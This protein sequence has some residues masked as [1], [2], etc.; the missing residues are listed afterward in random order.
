L[1]LLAG[2]VAWGQPGP[3][4][5]SVA[6]VVAREVHA[7]RSFAG[8]VMPLRASVV[9][10]AVDGRVEEFLVNEGDRVTKGQPLARLRT[11]LLEIQIAGAKAE[12][13]LRKHEL[14][15]LKNGS[16]PEEIAQAQ[17]KAA[18]SKALYEYHR[19][20][21]QRAQA[22]R[23]QPR[24]ISEDEM[25]E[26]TSA[27][28]SALQTLLE[29]KA[30]LA[31]ALAGPRQER[32]QQAEARV[33][34]AEEAIHEL[35]DQL[36]KHTIVAPFDGYVVEENTEVGQWVIRGQAVAKV[37]E[38][39]QVDVQSL[40]LEDYQ[41]LLALGMEAVVRLDALP[42][43]QFTGRI[44]LVVPQADLRSRSFPVKVRLDNQDTPGGPLLK[45]GMLAR[46]SLAV[47][48][49]A[50]ALLAPK[51][52]L[53]LGSEKPYVVA[54]EGGASAGKPGKAR[55]VPVDVGAAVEGLIQIRPLADLKPG[56]FVIVEGNERVR[57]GQDVVI[58][59]IVEA[60]AARTAAAPADEGAAID[61]NPQRKQG[62]AR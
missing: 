1:I 44:A 5:V 13:E 30:A 29:S 25:Q 23:N 41:P 4:P 21:L 55:P 34:F 45:P 46:V 37:V 10:S 57:P 52:A 9:G 58:A 62:E 32:I 60:P 8:T 3:V 59:K 38:L 42:N 20:R 16:R 54:A 33:A 51:D 14:A 6:A 40:V 11:R 2:R 47:G 18:A 12:H 61:T 19:G 48:D 53:V 15:E 27:T 22:L 28:E 31:L 56:D 24:A 35:E 49:K 7:T 26:A 43:R 50:L 36:D 39:G 17:A